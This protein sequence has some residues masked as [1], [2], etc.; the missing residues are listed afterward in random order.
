MKWLRS[1]AKS[2]FLC[3]ENGVE[4]HSKVIDESRLIR[5]IRRRFGVVVGV[6]YFDQKEKTSNT[7][8]THSRLCVAVQD[9]PRWG[10]R[11]RLKTRD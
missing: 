8:K 11:G 9:T 7:S 10:Q 1:K 6:V 4:S 3:N 2:P 5:R